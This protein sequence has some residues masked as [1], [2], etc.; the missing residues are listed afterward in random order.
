MSPALVHGF[1]APGL[2]AVGAAFAA[3]EEPGAAL[4]VVHDGT[5]VI[6]L[7]CGA[8]WEPDTLVNVFSATKPIAALC[9][10][11]LVDAGRLE[12]DQPVSS[13]WPEYAIAG[14]ER[15]T[16]R[17]VLAHGA[18]LLALSEPATLADYLDWE[19]CTARL[20]A[21]PPQWEPGTR[22]GEHALF[23]GH[24]TGELVRRVDG[25]SLGTYLREELCEPLGLD[26][27]IGLRAGELGR[28]LDVLDPGG[29]WRASMLDGADER[30]R[31]ALENPPAALE[32][33]VLNSLAWRRAEVPGV[34]GHATA[35]SLAHLYGAL[36]TG[37][38]L[39]GV[40]IL[41]R[42]LLAEAVAVQ[43]EGHDELLGYDVRWGLGMMLDGDTFGMGG[44]GGT[45]A[46]G[47]E[48][49]RLGFAFVPRRLGGFERAT[50]IEEALLAAL[51]DV[52]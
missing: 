43:A 14:K 38:E 12:L 9:V 35:R 20:A 24:L 36:A 25:R 1:V 46:W 51:A 2:E 15:T 41:G 19:R 39:D 18:G 48:T 21:E 7:R 52:A 34:N 13:V 47:D 8:G 40:R 10:L 32:V 11:R 30:K 33:D 16:V 3:L 49:R 5:L 31:R 42:D 27:H 37:G 50:A 28:V 22:H 6:D 17:H 4:A 44:I 45:V 29:A 26:M 23:Y